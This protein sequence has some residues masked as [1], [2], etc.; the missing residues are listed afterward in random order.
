ML[1]F[2]TPQSRTSH[3]AFELSD[4]RVQHRFPMVDLLLLGAQMTCQL[5]GLRP[6]LLAHVRLDVAGN[7]QSQ[8]ARCPGQLQRFLGPNRVCGVDSSYPGSWFTCARLR[9]L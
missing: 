5:T 8:L 6:N 9:F 2:C 1:M 4:S 7:D 3:L